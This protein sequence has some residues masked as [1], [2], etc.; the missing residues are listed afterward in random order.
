MTLY[1]ITRHDKPSLGCNLRSRCDMVTELRL[2]I[3]PARPDS[4]IHLSDRRWMRSNV[5]PMRAYYAI[6][7]MDA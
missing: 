7:V 4:A 2:V 3:L 5:I 1:A 6:D